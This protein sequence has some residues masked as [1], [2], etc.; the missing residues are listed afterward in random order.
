MPQ[1][2]ENITI[3]ITVNKANEE[4]GYSGSVPRLS[5]Q[6]R[7]IP[8][9]GFQS[10]GQATV[11]VWDVRI[12]RQWFWTALYSRNWHRTV[13]C[14]FTEDVQQPSEP[15]FGKGSSETSINL[16]RLHGFIIQNI[17]FFKPWLPGP[18]RKKVL[19]EIPTSFVRNPLPSMSMRID[20][21]K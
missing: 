9:I 13:W 15:L 4:N 10:F 19:S 20:E 1:D 11:S 14:K 12:Q 17:L 5:Q 3:R 8:L 21:T 18:I 16:T 6:C 2:S 7:L